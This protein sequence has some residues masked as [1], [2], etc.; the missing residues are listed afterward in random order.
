VAAL[1]AE[2][3]QLALLLASARRSYTRPGCIW[4]MYV[5]GYGRPARSAPM[6]LRSAPLPRRWGGPAPIC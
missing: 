4:R 5:P 6:L 2:P 3:D 1:Q